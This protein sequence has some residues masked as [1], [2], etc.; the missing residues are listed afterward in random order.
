MNSLDELFNGLDSTTLDPCDVIC[1]AY[2]DCK[3]VGVNLTHSLINARNLSNRIVG[4][5]N[6]NCKQAEIRCLQEGGT[7][8]DY[9]FYEEAASEG[10]IGKLR[11]IINRIIE[12]WR[13][14]CRKISLQVRTKLCGA[15]AKTTVKRM[16]KEVQLNPGLAQKQVQAPDITS[17]LSVIS[18]Y[19]KYADLNDAK[20]VKGLFSTSELKGFGATVVDFAKAFQNATV[21]A[22]A[23]CVITVAGLILAIEQEMDKLPIYVG[24]LEQSQSHILDRLSQTV[25]DETAVTAAAA[26]QE[27]ANFRV[28]L[29][30]QELET[31]MKYL[32]DLIKLAKE[33]LLNA[34]G[35]G[36]INVNV[37]E[38][39]DD[40]IG[41]EGF[42]SDINSILGDTGSE[43]FTEGANIDATKIFAE[44]KKDYAAFMK[45]CKK[46]YRDGNYP[47]AKKKLAGAVR[48][49]DKAISNIDAL[50]GDNTTSIL[51]G[52]VAR[53]ILSSLKATLLGAVT[54]GIGSLASMINDSYKQIDGIK[55]D[56]DN[57]GGYTG[58]AMNSYIR[59]F[60]GSI[61]R[62]KKACAKMSEK[63]NE[64][65]KAAKV[66]ESWN[67]AGYE[68][69]E[70]ASYYTEGAN[71]ED[72]F[73]DDLLND[74]F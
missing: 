23:T 66:E 21:G 67:F 73:L 74:I 9:S 30:K 15:Q 65:E 6:L 62:M 19:R 2:E 55:E 34:K 51:L 18:Q 69:D 7:Q 16:K 38:S 57:K 61:T 35:K 28:Q 37:T 56:I 47:E 64:A 49:L 41:S 60:K 43:Y 12:F 11:A 33:Q 1:E 70:D 25:S 72:T 32:A 20:L 14:L 52:A 27:A 54:F 5:Y 4:D 36:T 46:A 48:T 45:D 39:G 29:G 13:D 53:A 24:N 40:P 59:T 68:D 44:M 17:A 10:A 71:N 58:S 31:H 3:A 63:I 42:I 26:L 50:E 22:A 8:S